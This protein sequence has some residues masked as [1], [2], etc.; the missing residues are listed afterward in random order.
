MPGMG[1]W[2]GERKEEILYLVQSKI[3]LANITVRRSAKP[4]F[5][6]SKNTRVKP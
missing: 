5:S 6:L 3:E 2:Y 1:K 4:T